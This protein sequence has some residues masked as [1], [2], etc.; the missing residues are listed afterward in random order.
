MSSSPRCG[1]GTRAGHT[2]RAPAM[3]GKTRCR[4]HG[5]AP[6][7]GAPRGNRNARKHGAFTSDVIAEQ[8]AAMELLDE[9][10]R[11]LRKLKP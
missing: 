4:L 7:S 3:R 1:A 2:C 11:M 6:G 8:R 5:G 9:T 10:G